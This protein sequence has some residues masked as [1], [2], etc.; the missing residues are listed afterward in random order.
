MTKEEFKQIRLAM[1]LKQKELAKLLHVNVM[2]ISR[3]ECGY[4]PVPDDKA[5]LLEYKSR[6]Q[7]SPDY[8]KIGNIMYP[9][10][11][12]ESPYSEE[13]ARKIAREAV[14]AIK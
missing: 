9:V 8:F 4:W 1:N 10:I 5:E 11:H 3:W 7:L 2:T 12:S 14:S 6:E 13:V